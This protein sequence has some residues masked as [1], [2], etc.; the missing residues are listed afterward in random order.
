MYRLNHMSCAMRGAV[1][2]IAACAAGTALAQGQSPTTLETP[3]VEVVGSTPVPGLAMPKDEVPS[4]IQVE[5]GERME[6]Q[7]SLNLPEFMQETLPSVY[8]QEI[9]NSPY[10]PN[11][12]YRGFLSSP[13]L[14]TPQGISVY[15]DGVRVNEP[16]GDIV[17]YDLIPQNAVS[18]MTLVPGSNPIYGLNTIGGAIDIR[19]KSGAYYPGGEATFS[20]GSW[21]RKQAD[22]AWGGYDEKTDYFFA[23]NYFDEDGWRDFSPSEVGQLFGKIGWDNGDTDID[24]AITI[25]DTDLTGN[26]VTPQSFLEQ[27]WESIYT[28]PDNTQNELGMINLSGTHWLNDAWQLSGLTYYRDVGTDTLNGDANDDFEDGPN[29]GVSA[30]E[31]AV[32]NRSRTDQSGWGLGLQASWLIE[33]NILAFGATYDT[34]DSEFSQTSQEGVFTPDR[35]VTPTEPV[36]IEN[37]LEG[38]TTTWSLYFTDTYNATDA[39]A[40]TF[41][42]RYNNTDVK[43][44]DKFVLTPPNLDGDHTYKKF[45]PAIGATYLINPAVTTYLGWNQGSRAPS[46]IELGCA[47]PANPCTLPAGLASDP[48]LKQVVAQ[49]VEGGFRGRVGTA[50][51]Q[52]NAGLFQTNVE[53]D[54]LFVGTSTSAGYFTNF[55]KTRRQGL[56][57]GLAGSS[58]GRFVWS[59]NYSFIDATFQDT[60]CLLSENNSSRGQSAACTSPEGDLILVNSGE[61]LPGVPEHQFRLA[62]DYWVTN[63]WSIGGSVVA[64]SESYAYGNENNLHAPGTFTD[65]NGD[66]RT[67]EGAGKVDSYAVVNLNTRY[68]FSN[69]LEVFGKITNLFDKRY[70]STA[71]L[72]ENAFDSN[73]NFQIDSDDWTHEQ[74]DAPGAPLGGFIGVKYRF[75]ARKPRS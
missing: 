25:A 31:S 17:N 19:T 70:S 14:G 49:T 53:D 13:L 30:D 55:G 32:L 43:T 52:W 6:Q 56:E 8:I 68:V 18:T 39:L 15:Q 16:F 38:E 72:A 26:G 66:T 37:I 42:G 20:G 40:I 50:D 47:D 65:L 5:T 69:G 33:R 27:R 48:Y 64:F 22:F 36:E 3:S 60:A 21:G 59:A 23:V 51:M 12:T 54:I 74:F 2:V 46:P 57:A 67:F 71:I 11:L 41:S 44:T 34:S 28:Y 9:Q 75:G 61:Q 63:R 1:T 35:A 7:Q 4:N 29:D 58:T 73:G 24:L 10:Q 45:N 62:G